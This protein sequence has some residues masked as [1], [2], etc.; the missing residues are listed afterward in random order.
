MPPTITAIRAAWIVAVQTMSSS[1]MGTGGLDN[2]W[3][4]AGFRLLLVYSQ[5]E[6]GSWK[7]SDT[8][9]MRIKSLLAPHGLGHD[10]AVK[11]LEENVLVLLHPNNFPLTKPILQA[12]WWCPRY[13]ARPMT[14]AWVL[15]IVDV[16]SSTGAVMRTLSCWV[17][18]S[19]RVWTRD[20]TA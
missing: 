1:E 11:P 17:C 12:F 16:T 4:T 3:A 18:E 10:D 7:T 19:R 15:G 6:S 14:N 5:A 9:P 20:G 13:E 8:V 2:G